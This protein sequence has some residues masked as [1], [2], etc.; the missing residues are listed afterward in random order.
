MNHHRLQIGQ[1]PIAVR[2][3]ELT[4]PL[5]VGNLETYGQ[6]RLALMWQGMPVGWLDLAHGGEATIPPTV[7]QRAVDNLPWTQPEPTIA[8]DPGVSVSIVIATCD[9]PEALKRCLESLMGQR[10]D[11]WVEILVIDNRPTQGPT[12]QIATAFPKV[13]YIAEARPGGSFA[14]N[15]GFAASRGEIVITLDDDVVVPPNW[16]EQMVAP[17]AQSDIDVVTGNLLPLALETPSQQIFEIY[18]GSLGRGFTSFEADYQ[19]FS[20]RLLAVPTWELGATAMAAFRARTILDDPRVGWL[21]EQLGP[22]VPSGAGEDLYFFYRI[23]QA[24]RRLVYEPR[25]W[26]WHEH[27]RTMP[28]L[29]QQLF[30]YSKGNIGYHLTVLLRHRDL[31]VL[32]TVLVFLPIYYAKR[33]LRWVWGDRAYPLSLIWVE[34]RGILAGPW[35]LWQSYWLIR[36]IGRSR[37]SRDRAT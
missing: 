11:R 32:P 20:Q 29:R 30:N 31:R 21:D 33:L 15:A 6:V 37:R 2:A 25:A 19:W 24:R 36:K 1:G 35:G 13:R 4:E 22:G 17:F 18:D 23:L 3:L 5:Q 12:E 9:R 16:L 27:R 7:L 14:R 10:S 26:G 28:E 34:I 8:L